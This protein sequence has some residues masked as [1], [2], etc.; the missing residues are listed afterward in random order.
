MASAEPARQ[1]AF[2]GVVA[3]LGEVAQQQIGDLLEATAG[4]AVED[5]VAPAPALED[6]HRRELPE[7]PRHRRLAQP[8]QPRQLLGRPWL[9][10]DEAH[11]LEAGA[12]PERAQ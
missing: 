3:I 9:L 8:D 10:T 6:P 5:E 2:S 4:D 1:R 12:I 11:R 7:V